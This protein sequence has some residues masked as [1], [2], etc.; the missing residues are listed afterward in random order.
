NRFNPDFKLKWTLAGVDHRSKIPKILMKKFPMINNVILVGRLD[1]TEIVEQMLHS[2]LF[3]LPSAI[4]NS[5]NAL[6]EAMLIGMPVIATHSGGTSVFIE[7]NQ[8]GILIPEGE[9]YSLA[10]AITELSQNYSKAIEFGKK[11]RE[12]ALSRNN[13]E[14][15]AKQLII[16]YKNIMKSSN[17]KNINTN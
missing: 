4:E 8:D 6:Q 16:A 11:A 9:P 12:R 14:V 2:D 1:S 3:V 15:I 5:P 10:G 13:P 7:H 17:N